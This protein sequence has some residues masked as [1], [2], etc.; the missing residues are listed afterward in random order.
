MAD[1]QIILLPVGS[2]GCRTLADLVNQTAK[3]ALM[4]GVKRIQ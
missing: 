4:Q 1:C 3:D 2:A